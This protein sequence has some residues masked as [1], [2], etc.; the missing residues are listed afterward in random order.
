M[1][2]SPVLWHSNEG[3]CPR[4]HAFRNDSG[5]YGPIRDT[6]LKRKGRSAGPGSGWRPNN[7]ASWTLLP[8]TLKG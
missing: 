1:R 4:P 5:C 8:G 3:L 2:Q 6:G 7:S